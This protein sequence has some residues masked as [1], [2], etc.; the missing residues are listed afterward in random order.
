MALPNV[1]YLLRLFKHLLKQV[2][3][4]LGFGFEVGYFEITAFVDESFEAGVVVG[5]AVVEVD[6]DP[7]VSD[8]LQFR[9][10]VAEFE[11][12]FL[13]D[14]ELFGGSFFGGGAGGD[15]EFGLEPIDFLVE[16]DLEFEN[17]VGAEAG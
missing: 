11:L 6:R 16:F 1:L 15:R 2:E 13:E 14:F 10:V 17:V 8:G 4:P 9:L 12:L 7:L 3:F 5:N